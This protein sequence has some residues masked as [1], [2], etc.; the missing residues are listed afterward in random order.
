MM[1]VGMPVCRDRERERNLFV[2]NW[3]TRLQRFV[4]FKDRWGRWAGWRLWE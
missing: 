3:L 4:R 2:R 1:M